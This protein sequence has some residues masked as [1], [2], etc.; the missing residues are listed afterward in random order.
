MLAGLAVAGFK[1]QLTGFVSSG[2]AEQVEVGHHV[3]AAQTPFAQLHQKTIEPVAVH[4]VAVFLITGFTVFALQA[5]GIE[6]ATHRVMP[7]AAVASNRAEY[8]PHVGVTDIALCQK[9]GVLRLECVGHVVALG[10]F[11]LVVQQHGHIG[12]AAQVGNAQGNAPAQ[13]P[14]PVRAAGYQ[15][16][17]QHQI[18]SKD[19]GMVGHSG[20]GQGGEA[21]KTGFHRSCCI[22]QR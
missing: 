14:R 1:M 3:A 12:L 17:P 22:F 4:A 8:S 18:V 11:L 16:L 19:G 13:H 10:F 2:F 15:F 6:H 21:C 5:I 9:R 7:A 20:S